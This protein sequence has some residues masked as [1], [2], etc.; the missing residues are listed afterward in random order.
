MTIFLV[1]TPTTSST[2][3]SVLAVEMLYKRFR[4]FHSGMVG[5]VAHQTLLRPLIAQQSILKHQM[6]QLIL[7]KVKMLDVGS[8]DGK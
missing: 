4:L 2:K 7:A 3:K 5:R 6:I 1:E 8:D